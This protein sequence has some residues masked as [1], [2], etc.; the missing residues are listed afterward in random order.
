MLLNVKENLQALSVSELN[1]M[2]K[3]SLENSF[4]SVFVL[5]EISKIT[6]HSSGHWYFTIKD[7]ISSIDCVMFSSFNK[8]CFKPSVGNR[9]LLSGKLTIYPNTGKYQLNVTN[10]EIYDKIGVLQAKF[11]ELHDKLNKEGIFNKNK[12]FPKYIRKV[13]VITANNSAAM[14]DILRIYNN[15]KSYLIKLDFYDSLMQ[16]D[17]AANNIISVLDNISNKNYD[18]VLIARGGG[19]KEDLFCF[20]DENLVRKI[21]NYNLPIITGL[22]HEVDVHL[23][24]LAATKYY[25]TPTA[26]ID[27][28]CY[29]KEDRILFLDEFH[30]RFIKAIKLRMKI[31]EQDFLYLN[32][33][34]SK[35]D[36]INKINFFKN[37]LNNREKVLKQQIYYKLSLQNKKINSYNIHNKLKNSFTIKKNIF[38]A[39]TK[40]INASNYHNKINVINGKLEYINGLYKV[41]ISDRI[42]QKQNTLL[43]FQKNK[44]IVEYRLKFEKNNINNMKDLINTNTKRKIKE[45]YATIN[46]YY[47]I[48]K[49]NRLFLESIKEYARLKK[50]NKGVELRMLNIGDEINLIGFDCV[51]TAKIIEEKL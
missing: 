17:N 7:D 42:K 41:K 5:A 47:E 24:D 10:L 26:A 39:Y 3:N 19:S 36:A 51:K 6:M 31:I 45:K 48:L 33:K 32:S 30:N 34:F 14:H 16:G 28:I 15:K 25:A 1:N 22:G 50:D 29:N 13:A 38:N 49:T 40:S 21:A 35:R 23:S 27:A 18:L 12:I 9:V 4:S 2:A 20:N 8:I 43:L 37:I 11:K 46:T 44:N